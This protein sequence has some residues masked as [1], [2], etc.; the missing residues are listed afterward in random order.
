MINGEDNQVAFLPDAPLLVEYNFGNAATR[1]AF[2]KW[3][4]FLGSGYGWHISQARVACQ[5]DTYGYSYPKEDIRAHGPV[6]DA[7]M[8]FP[9]ALASL[10][11]RFSYQVNNNPGII[12]NMKG[13]FG[14]GV[15]YNS[16][17]PIYQRKRAHVNYRH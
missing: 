11:I 3:G 15:E 6:F 12:A 1:K 10:G 17:A 13:I 5:D 2:R 8:C 4:F 14:F 9:I 7:G 16:G